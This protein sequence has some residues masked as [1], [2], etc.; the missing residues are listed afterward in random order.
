MM[1]KDALIVLCQWH[2][3]GHFQTF[4]FTHLWFVV[5]KHWHHTIQIVFYELH[6]QTTKIE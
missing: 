4:Q 6:F 3:F 2:L 1:W 5:A